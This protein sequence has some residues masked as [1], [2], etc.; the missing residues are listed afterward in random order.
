MTRLEWSH[1][2]LQKKLSENLNKPEMSALQELQRSMKSGKPSDFKLAR[3]LTTYVTEDLFGTLALASDPD[4]P[5]PRYGVIAADNLLVQAIEE[6]IRAGLEAFQL[7]GLALRHGANPN[8]YVT[9][10]VLDDEGD[11]RMTV[12]H[13]IAY[14]WK[15]YIESGPDYNYL[16]A[17]IGLLC[18]AGSDTR[19]PV[20]DRKVL[21][22]RKRLAAPD[23][24]CVSSVDVLSEVGVPKSVLNLI[25]QTTELP[26]L[27]EGYPNEVLLSYRD[28][29]LSTLM[30]KQIAIFTAF[31]GTLGD[32]ARIT[33]DDMFT[34]G[35]LQLSVPVRG[36]DKDMAIDLAAQIGEALDDPS[37]ISGLEGPEKLRSCMNIHANRC[38]ELILSSQ[39]ITIGEAEDAFF[40]CVHAYNWKGIKL[41]IDNT[42]VPKYNHVDRILFIAL[43]KRDEALPISAE[44]LMGMLVF[45]SEYGTSLDNPQMRV[46]G[47]VSQSTFTRLSEIQLE[48]YW[49]RTCKAAGQH[50]RQDI[51]QLA[52]TLDLNPEL[53][54]ATMCRE[55]ANIASGNM[56]SL[57][58]ASV[59]LQ[60]EKLRVPEVT[61]GDLVTQSPVTPVES[62][63]TSDS[64]NRIE[65]HSL[66]EEYRSSIPEESKL[67][68][69][70]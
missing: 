19:L 1:V 24:S 41:M 61:L 18:A 28:D 29:F 2:E 68:E 27:L 43:K 58:S 12:L 39:T 65:V 22:E 20:T 64:Q 8:L 52:R 48:P 62:D 34:A 14:S 6:T 56:E 32:I 42:F 53:D 46:A 36:R 44:I 37:H 59:K 9:V 21:L 5:D 45:M 16:L 60:E 31:K 66:G 15:I 13:I 49:Q 67:L 51:R 33:S 4:S 47:I 69:V 30:L 57:N 63:V 3:M 40:E 17:I 7:A 26:E 54:K 35:D 25:A 23:P 11:E 38:A 10:R 70:Q 50:I 55:F